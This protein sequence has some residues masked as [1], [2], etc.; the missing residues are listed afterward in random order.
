MKLEEIIVHR[1][2]KHENKLYG[3]F[4]VKVN[5]N[6]YFIIANNDEIRIIQYFFG[7]SIEECLIKPTEE[8]EK[9]FLKEAKEMVDEVRV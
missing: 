1:G 8:F 7:S 3:R 5:G 2:F 4:E 6:T 9:L